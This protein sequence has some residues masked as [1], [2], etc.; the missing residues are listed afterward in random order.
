MAA[1]HVPHRDVAPVRPFRL[2]N[3][4]PVQ[5]FIPS[6]RRTY[7]ISPTLALSNQQPHSERA[8]EDVQCAARAD[9]RLCVAQVM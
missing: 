7:R 5:V 8:E 9:P 1:A 6:K 3:Y 4:K 2:R